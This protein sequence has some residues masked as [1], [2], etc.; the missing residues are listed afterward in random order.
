MLKQ[1]NL[2]F[3]VGNI[4]TMKSSNLVTKSWFESFPCDISRVIRPSNDM[5]TLI[6]MVIGFIY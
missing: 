2:A 3:S 5:L 1:F 4:I 6:E